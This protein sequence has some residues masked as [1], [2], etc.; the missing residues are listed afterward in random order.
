VRTFSIDMSRFTSNGLGTLHDPL[1]AELHPASASP[2][3]TKTPTPWRP[4]LSEW[5]VTLPRSRSLWDKV[6]HRA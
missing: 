2:S 4:R 6:L 3:P 5:P 1:A